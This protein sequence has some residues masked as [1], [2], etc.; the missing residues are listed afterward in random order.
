VKAAPP[1]KPL[2]KSASTVP[3]ASAAAAAAP[4]PAALRT[5]TFPSANAAKSSSVSSERG[6]VLDQVLPDVS[7]KARSTIHGHVRVAVRA[8]VDAAGNVSTAELESPGPSRYFAD[9]ALKAARSWEFTP[10]EAAGRSVPSQW[11]I[12]FVFSSSG[13]KASP[14]QV[15]P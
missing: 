10:P 8:H 5:D 12:H 1:K 2:E 7:E 15:A 13:T 14:Q 11:L 3:P 9:L 6:D 4:A